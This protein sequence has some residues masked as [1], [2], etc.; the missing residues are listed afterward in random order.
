MHLQ[1]QFRR[2]PAPV[3]PDLTLADDPVDA[4]A[5]NRAET[6]LEP[7]IEAL[8]RPIFPHLEVL[9]PGAVFARMAVRNGAFGV[10]HCFYNALSS[11]L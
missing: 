8:T 4:A 6:P 5:R 3:H 10:R 11:I 7:V 1:A 9:H 2:R